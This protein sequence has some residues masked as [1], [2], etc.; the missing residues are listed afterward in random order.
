MTN[1][2][3]NFSEWF[4]DLDKHHGF[5]AYT[6]DAM[7]LTYQAAHEA[8]Q[9]RI[10]EL[11]YD[12]LKAYDI[13]LQKEGLNQTYLRKIT[14]LEAENKAWKADNH[15]ITHKLLTCGVA[16]SHPD[17]NLSKRQADYGGKWDSPAAQDVRKLRSS[18]ISLE[19]ENARL[20]EALKR[21][22]EDLVPHH[23]K[24]STYESVNKALSTKSS[25]EKEVK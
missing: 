21:A 15:L 1:I 4:R 14:A 19:A 13:N 25:T 5:S 11:I 20:R 3:D 7:I 18:Y 9:K 2:R 10:D 6:R 8:Q 24:P 12:N 23:T 17:A 16:A 22:S